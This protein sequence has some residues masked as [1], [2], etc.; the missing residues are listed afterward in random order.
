MLGNNY[1]KRLE[2]ARN[3]LNR[4]GEMHHKHIMDSY[5]RIEE[6]NEGIMYWSSPKICRMEFRELTPQ[7]GYDKTM[8]KFRLARMDKFIKCYIDDKY[9]VVELP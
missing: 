1:S 2:E 9:V 4:I 6:D 3:G 5:P 7:Q 8:N